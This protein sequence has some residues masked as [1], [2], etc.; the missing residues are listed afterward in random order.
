MTND[1]AE[2]IGKPVKDIYGSYMGK[3]VGT[4]TEIDGSIQSVG[5]NCGSMGLQMIPDE[6]LVIQGDV[7]IFIP[8]WRLDSQR[9]IREKELTLRRLRAMIDIVAGNDEMKVDAEIVQERYHAKLVLLQ[10]TADELNATLDA[11]VAELE[12]QSRS[13]KM[14]FFDAK[15]QYKSDEITEKMFDTVRL[16]TGEL[17]EHVS[18][19]IGEIDNIK[20][21]I[22][23]LE[24]EVQEVNELVSDTADSHMSAMN[25]LQKHPAEPATTTLLS[26]VSGNTPDSKV[27]IEDDPAPITATAPTGAD[28]VQDALKQAVG[29]PDA[30][31]E[32]ATMTASNT[33]VVADS[34]QYA[35]STEVAGNK[36]EAAAAAEPVSDVLRAEVATPTS[37]VVAPKADMTDVG[38]PTTAEAAPSQFEVGQQ[39]PAAAAPQPQQSPEPVDNTAPNTMPD[40]MLSATTPQ[41]APPTSPECLSAICRTPSD[42]EVAF[43]EP[44]KHSTPSNSPPK[45]DDDWLSRMESQ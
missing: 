45:N 37:R 18:H 34:P 6:H 30:N 5:V 11:R 17:I 22:R 1:D 25:Y 42:S 19:E 16:S 41:H 38:A 12:D 36:G 27:T 26:E 8:K 13:A 10:T 2:I 4:I 33:D 32:S 15:I 40:P 24:K 39:P 44:P 7:V 3:V 35:P 23:G 9:L 31:L 43:P 21:R 14:L 28:K 29:Q 20:E